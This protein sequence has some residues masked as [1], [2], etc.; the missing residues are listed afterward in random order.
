MGRSLSPP[1]CQS[2]AATCA[3]ASPRARVERWRPVIIRIRL[4]RRKPGGGLRIACCPLDPSPCQ[5][6]S[7]RIPPDFGLAL[8]ACASIQSGDREGKSIILLSPGARCAVG[9]LFI[10]FQLSKRETQADSSP[11]SPSSRGV[12][13]GGGLHERDE[14][15]GQRSTAPLDIFSVAAL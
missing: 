4:E 15:R 9:S 8:E 5:A 1:V 10:T 13:L 3:G 6:S 7:R 11:C 12:S 2:A 14:L